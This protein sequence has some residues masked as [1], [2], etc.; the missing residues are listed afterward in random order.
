MATDAATDAITLRRVLRGTLSNYAGKLITLG[1]GFFLTPFLLHQ[2]GVDG[3]GLW[4]LVGSVVAYSSLLDFGIYTAVI[5]YV[6]EYRA[7]GEAERAHELVATSLRLYTVLGIIA[8]ALSAA[9]APIFPAIFNVP[10]EERASATWLVLL[11]GTTVGISLPCMTVTAVLR[12]LHRFDLVNLVDTA[13]ALISA[14]ATV[15]TLLLGGGVLGMV[16]INIPVTLAM[17]AVSVAFVNRAAPEL[18]FG[19]QGAR[20]ESV[21]TVLSFSLSPLVTNLAGKLK[22]RTDEVV[23]GA[24]LPISAVAP[25]AIARRLSEVAQLLTNQF[26]KVIL[27]LASE[28]DAQADRARLRLLYTMGTRLTLAIFLPIGCT[29]AILAGPILTVW[30]GAA[31]ADYAELV[32]ILAVAGLVDTSMWPAAAILQ[33]M[34]R[35]RPLVVMSICGALA[36]V[37]LS[38]VLVRHLGLTGIALGTLIPT[39]AEALFVLPYATRVMGVSA[40]AALKEVFLPAFVPAGLMVV[41]LSTL[42]QAVAPSSLLSIVA[43]TTISLLV[44]AGSY[45]VVGATTAERQLCR[46]CAIGTLRLVSKAHGAR[47]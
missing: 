25:Y 3:Y 5:K 2:L 44:Y 17:Q 29:V 31:Y 26:M 35:L 14:A 38:I 27:P 12:G 7:R 32:V 46:A 34:A 33:G 45:F 41:V 37:V 40:G 28:F 19:W 22:T 36:N 13:G 39:V 9:V 20:R 6:A 24:F 43:V 16:A 18:R 47:P 1:T 30:V 8:I 10:P 15:I 11:M 23:I 4:V 42:Q 21:R